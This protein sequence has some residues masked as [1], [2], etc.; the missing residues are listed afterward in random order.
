MTSRITIT[1]L[2][3]ALASAP[4]VY[5]DSDTQTGESQQ[6]A[7]PAKKTGMPVFTPTNLGAP[8]TRLGGATRGSQDGVP[9][10]EALVPEEP[11]QTWNA[12]PVLYWYLAAKTDHRIDFTLIG[13]DPIR[14][15]RRQ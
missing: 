13:V 1:A 4:W 11:G 3:L 7:V 12:Q 5:A 9:R 14:R 6:A 10:T 15:L 2:C 8:K